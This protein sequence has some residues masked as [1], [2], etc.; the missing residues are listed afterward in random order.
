MQIFYFTAEPQR[1][2][3]FFF[4]DP[5]FSPTLLEKNLLFLFNREIPVK[6]PEK[7]G[8]LRSILQDKQRLNKTNNSFG[9]K[10]IILKRST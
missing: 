1:T 7:R 4:L 8:L 2:Q 3:R 5:G 9:I 10:I 6:S